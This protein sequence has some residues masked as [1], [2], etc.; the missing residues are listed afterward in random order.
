MPRRP[1]SPR[2]PPL[3]PSL[4]RVSLLLATLALCVPLAS[5]QGA[6][7][8]E[9][10]I[11]NFRIHSTQEIGTVL[12]SRFVSLDSAGRI[13]YSSEGELS[14]F[15][16][17]E[18]KRLS[19]ARRRANEDIVAVSQGPDGT[20][21]VGGIGYWGRLQVDSQG[22]YLV[23]RF[24]TDEEQRE[25][26]NERFDGIAFCDGAVFFKSLSNLVRWHPEHGTKIWK[27]ARIDLIF[28]FGGELYLSS[29]AGI[30]KLDGDRFIDVDQ[31]K[32]LS[33]GDS[34]TLRSAPW[35]KG[36]VV[37]FNTKRG[38]VLFDGQTFEDID[39]AF[40]TSGEPNWAHDMERVDNDTF[41]ISILQKG[42]HLVDRSGN[43]ILKFDQRLDRRFLDCGEIAVAPDKSIWVA[44]S[45]GVAQIP[46]LYPITYFDQRL[47]LPLNYF[48][49]ARIGRDL[50]IR[51]SGRLFKAEYTKT[52]RVSS[53][54][55]YDVLP[56]ESVLEILQYKDGILASTNKA[57]YYLQLDKEP[58]TVLSLPNVY[59]LQETLHTRAGAI[60]LADPERVYLAEY[61]D[62]ALE[63]KGSIPIPGTFNKILDDDKGNLWLERGIANIGRI[64]ISPEGYA[65]REYDPSSG[66]TSDQ[67]ISIWR[68]R[69]EVLFSTRK[70]ALRFDE[71]K[72]R[73]E[74]ADDINALIPRK[75]KM[76][77]RPAYSP[78]GDL[79]VIANENPVVLRKQNDGTFEADY[80]TL[81]YLG[82][83]PLEEIQFDSLTGSVWLL[84][85]RTLAQV[86]DSR[87]KAPPALP[88]PQ[89][90]HI[91]NLFSGKTYNHFARNDIP[92]SPE[93]EHSENSLQ[94][95]TSTP[96]YQGTSGI[97]YSYRLAGDTDQWTEPTASSTISLDR[98]PTGTYEFQIKSISETGEESEISAFPVI[99]EPPPYRTIPAYLAYF[100]AFGCSLYFLL[101]IRHKKLT[102]R[103]Q[104]LEE[105]VAIQ[106]KALR[107]KNIQIHGALLNERE[108][109]K[110]AEKA[111][112]AKSEFLAMVS[113]EIRTPMNCIIGM[114][115]NLLATP[116]EREQFD[117]LRSIHSSGQSL[118]AIIADI[119]D[120]SKI[121]AGKIEIEQIPF[122]PEQL[123]RDV[124]NLFIRSCNEKKLELRTEISPHLPKVTIGDPTRIKQVLI[125]LVGNSLKFTEYGR[126]DIAL[127]RQANSDLGLS[128]LF[129]VKDTGLGIAQD[130]MDLLFK[131]FTQ[132]DSSNTR[133]FGGTG[134]GLV[135]SKRLANQMGGDIGVSS[136]L[137]Q[138]STFSF[139]I[140]TR[141][142]S[143]EETLQFDQTNFQPI[144]ASLPFAPAPTYAIKND[145]AVSSEPKDVLLVE[146]NPINQQV[147][148]MMLRR[149]GFTC[150]VVGNGKSACQAIA[151][152]SYKVIL[153]DIQ[154]PEM[155]GIECAKRVL[156]ENGDRTPPI[157][158]VTAKSS[159][160]DRE[161]AKAAGMAD[162]LTK[163]LERAKLK[164]AIDSAL[165]LRNTPKA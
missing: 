21:Y 14:G 51:T 128:L 31:E 150:D 134:L 141:I 96:Y 15:D 84:S 131:S 157:I 16:G 163:P 33:N 49:Q 160:S 85:K 125:N 87:R 138:G 40:G 35:D 78:D 74:L 120:F 71:E 7:R 119:L 127:E 146:D 23:E 90:T 108:L 121:E 151:K 34:R 38:L 104:L 12:G 106:T 81:R 98:I 88:A 5:T 154:M 58:T 13:L 112:R 156:S 77:S 56:N 118:V 145:N 60:V 50:L 161:I 45:D 130:K 10:G 4:V 101:K 80:E 148:A 61:I 53:F 100:A 113:H 55:P 29:S 115:D 37:L 124:Y 152:K 67:W 69:G 82:K 133:K 11:P 107:E 164:E 24:L 122:S 123:V 41:A 54:L 155:D 102:R 89:F 76:V 25:T 32:M 114:A 140:A 19:V 165:Q 36:H 137:G 39:D 162:F 91:S 110:R 117:M 105:K 57:V 132:I 73:F 68:N 109:K 6:E 22:M 43:V 83:L 95:Q 52:G 99:V 94:I 153:M 46:S 59:R 116:L 103:Q 75:T 97:K 63:I 143:D 126:I 147:T 47:D 44:L 17:T 142:A 2:T 149:I 48:D 129:T 9:I 1:T 30:Q 42:L 66:I 20:L 86:D 70:G 64:T 18:W 144:E 65:Y 159:D 111:N 72:D 62:G 139:S 79:W 93:L 8:R 135:I 26:S 136:A 27:L 3:G 28:E 158:A 92:I